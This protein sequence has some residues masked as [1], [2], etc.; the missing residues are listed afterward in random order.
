[1]IDPLLVD[2]PCP[3]C[4]APA[5]ELCTR[6]DGAEMESTVHAP[7]RVRA[8]IPEPQPALQPRKDGKCRSGAH[9]WNEKNTYED[10]GKRRCALC[11][12]ERQRRKNGKS[13][14]GRPPLTHC[15]QG[16]EFTPQNTYTSPKGAR[17]CRACK[18]I[19]TR[20]DNARRRKPKT[21]TKESTK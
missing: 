14:A 20:A 4:G 9:D 18:T 17:R 6:A 3:M 12:L 16:H 11:R 2:V 19:Q 5:L 15:G 10:G 8:N 21:N 1:M 7:R 13:P